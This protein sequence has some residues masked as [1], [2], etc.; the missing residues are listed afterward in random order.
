MC[1]LRKI[2]LQVMPQ[3]KNS[4]RSSVAKYNQDLFP[5]DYMFSKQVGRKVYSLYLKKKRLHPGKGKYSITCSC[6]GSAQLKPLPKSAT[7][8]FFSIRFASNYMDAGKYS[9]TF[10][11]ERDPEYLLQSNNDYCLIL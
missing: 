9:S 4:L 8:H 10:G 5:T 3:K 6:I 2:N 7:S 1:L 11:L